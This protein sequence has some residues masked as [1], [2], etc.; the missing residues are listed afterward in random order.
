MR[1]IKTIKHFIS[2]EECK[3]IVEENSVKNL[4]Q[5]QVSGDLMGKDLKKIRDTKVINIEIPSLKKR[6]EDLLKAEIR[7]K[8]CELSDITSFQ[9][10]KY[11]IDG[12]YDWHTDSGAG[13]IYED[14]FCTIVIQL[15]NDYEGGELLY[16]EIDSDDVTFERG[17]GNLHI[18]NSSLSHKVTPVT[19]GNR[20]ALVSWINLRIAESAKKSLI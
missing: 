1:F 8:G 15:N 9:F 20:F 4:E 18:F 16:K 14:R 11:E 19:S 5:G 13:K 17:I 3:K 6:I 7:I 12:H 10:V 2:E